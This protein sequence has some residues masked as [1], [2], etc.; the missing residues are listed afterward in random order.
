MLQDFR[1]L[2]RS[3]VY[4]H[5]GDEVWYCGLRRCMQHHSMA[6]TINY[7][8]HAYLDHLQDHNGDIAAAN[9]PL[10]MQGRNGEISGELSSWKS[11]KTSV[12][13]VLGPVLRRCPNRSAISQR[14]LIMLVPA[15]AAPESHPWG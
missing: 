2:D 12:R 1:W 8:R 14:P 3:L 4:G 6:S 10:D 11:H 15:V 7:L 5:S 13:K 9:G